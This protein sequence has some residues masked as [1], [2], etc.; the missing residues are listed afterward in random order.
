MM[1]VNFSINLRTCR[2]MSFSF[3]KTLENYQLLSTLRFFCIHTF[4]NLII[5]LKHEM[6]TFYFGCLMAALVVF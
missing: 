3:L 5:F 1:N 4:Y 6:V 2:K